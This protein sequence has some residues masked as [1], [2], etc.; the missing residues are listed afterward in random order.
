MCFGIGAFGPALTGMIIDEKV[1][2]LT[3]AGVATASGVMSLF[4]W[5]TRAQAT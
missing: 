5:R 3:L 2:Y 4:V 1:M